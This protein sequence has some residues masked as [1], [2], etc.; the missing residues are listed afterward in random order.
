MESLGI[1]IARLRKEKGFTQE[2]VATKFNITTQAVSKWENGASSPDIMILRDLSNLLGVSIDY[3]LYGEEEQIVRLEKKEINKMI[4]KTPSE[5]AL[6]I[7]A[8]VTVCGAPL[9]ANRNGRKQ[10]KNSPKQ[11]ALNIA[12][13][14]RV[15]RRP[16]VFLT[17]SE[18]FSIRFV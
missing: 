13:V 14:F 8:V 5:I 10:I 6:K 2:E 9:L 4:A 11:I 12:P 18:A 16:I 3:L 17:S 1:R 7:I 15:M